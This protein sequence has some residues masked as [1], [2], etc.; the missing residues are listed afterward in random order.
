MILINIFID[1]KDVE[2]DKPPENDFKVGLDVFRGLE[3]V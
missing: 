1:F 2:E 3:G